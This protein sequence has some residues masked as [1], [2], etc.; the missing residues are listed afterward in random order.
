LA[1]CGS[2]VRVGSMSRRLVCSSIIRDVCGE[3]VPAG[4]ERECI[5]ALCP[6][7]AAPGSPYCSDHR[8][9]ALQRPEFLSGPRGNLTP[10]NKRFRRRRRSFL[11]RHPIC[12]GCGHSFATVLDHRIPHRG[13]PVLFWDEANWQGLCRKCHGVKTAAEVLGRGTWKGGAAG[14]RILP[15]PP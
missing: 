13:D 8:A 11:C 9:A 6:N 5:R 14:Q 10:W 12:A 2:T 4:P 15:T 1:A 3:P 7:Y